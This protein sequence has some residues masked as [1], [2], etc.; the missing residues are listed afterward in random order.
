[1]TKECYD[2]AKK[3]M[4]ALF[5]EALENFKEAAKFEVGFDTH[6][7]NLTHRWSIFTNIGDTY[8][9]SA[10]KI[11]DIT[12]EDEELTQYFELYCPRHIK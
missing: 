5:D 11:L 4:G 3:I 12:N 2:F 1:M 6:D 8:V 9:M 7:D 10:I